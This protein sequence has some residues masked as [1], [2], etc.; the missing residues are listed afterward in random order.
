MQ[1]LAFPYFRSD[2]GYAFRGEHASKGRYRAFI[3]ADIDVIDRKLNIKA[4]AQGHCNNYTS[5]SSNWDREL[6]CFCKSHRHC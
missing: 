1:E 2:I 4:D 3:Q 5:A 6:Q